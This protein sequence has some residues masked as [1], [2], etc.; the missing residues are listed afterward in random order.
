MSKHTPGPWQVDGQTIYALMHHGWRKG[1]EQ[2]RNRFY[3]HVQAD[4]ECPDEEHEANVSLIAA[5]P[6]LLAALQAL[7]VETRHLDDAGPLG[8]EYQSDA[9]ESAIK[10][11]DAAIEKALGEQNG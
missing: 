6:D 3:V 7:L 1:V 5:A 9:L 10:A 4:K 11:S 2:F 8:Q